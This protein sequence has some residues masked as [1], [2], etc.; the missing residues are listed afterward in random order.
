VTGTAVSRLREAA[1]AGVRGIQAT[2][3]SLVLT[4]DLIFVH[5]TLVRRRRTTNDAAVKT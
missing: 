4:A 5:V 2:C 3:A 1:R